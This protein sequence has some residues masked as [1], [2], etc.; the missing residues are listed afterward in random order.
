MK[1]N[2]FSWNHWSINCSHGGNKLYTNNSVCLKICMY[3]AQIQHQTTH[4]G[5]VKPYGKRHFFFLF[6]FNIGSG[7]G[8]K[9]LPEPMLTDHQWSA[10]TLILRQFHKRCLKHQ[11]LVWKLHI[12]NFIHISQGL[13]PRNS[14]ND[15]TLGLPR[16]E[17]VNN[18]WVWQ[19]HIVIRFMVNCIIPPNFRP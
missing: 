6:F 11:W 1:K 14:E 12:Q 2:K 18:S 15:S 10:V 5:L 4:S 3:F 19:F 13:K 9:P 17:N 16:W 7:H 8:N